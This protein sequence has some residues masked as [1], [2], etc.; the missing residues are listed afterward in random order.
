MKPKQPSAYHVW[1][2]AKW[3]VDVEKLKPQK[4]EEINKAFEQELAKGFTTSKGITLNAKP[5]DYQFYFVGKERAKSKISKGVKSQ[6]IARVK[7][8]NG[9]SHKDIPAADY[10]AMIEEL[11][12]HLE[13]LWY[14]KIDLEEQVKA[15]AT[16][17]E[18]EAV[19]WV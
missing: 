17:G 18:L 5:T 8:H 12:E 3:V 16:V 9:A 19:K 11:E 1:D 15:A 4:L 7:D 6:L 10:V 2:G 13:S 14:Q